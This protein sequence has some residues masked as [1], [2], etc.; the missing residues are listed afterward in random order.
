M[1]NYRTIK[2][3]HDLLPNDRKI[4]RNIQKSIQLIMNQFGYGEIRTPVFENTDLFI[5]GIGTET[6]IVTKEMYSWVDQGNNHL[7]LKPE[8]TAP[9][10]RSYIQHQMGNENPINR[11]YYFDALFRRER[12]Q[13]GRLRQFHQFGAEAIGSSNPEQD[14][15]IITLAYNIY[16]KFNINNIQV[17]LNSIGSSSIRPIYLNKLRESI[18]SIKNKLCKTCQFRIEKNALRLFDCKNSNCQ[19]LLDENAPLIYNSISDEDKKH[20]ETI[21]QT[22]DKMKIPYIHDHKLVRGLD[23]YSHTTFEITSPSLGSQNA[24]CGGGRYNGLVKQLGGKSTPAVGFAAGVE[25][26]IL[27]LNNNIIIKNNIDIYIVHLGVKVISLACNIADDLRSKCGKIVLFETLRRSLKAQM[28]AAG[29]SGAKI[30]LILGENEL[31][32]NIIIIKNMETG[33]QKNLPINEIINY[34]S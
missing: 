23:Y 10:I 3:T 24:L 31:N 26:L 28:R 11:L 8:L 30:T 34:F 33:E 27:A 18:Q 9:V 15:E 29:K 2:G 21:I 17:R 32:N 1:S 16:K 20:F 6:D 13:K 25:R 22:L 14:I 12:P 5:R 4:W 7:T 19:I